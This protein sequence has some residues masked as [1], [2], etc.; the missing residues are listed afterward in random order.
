M[1]PLALIAAFAFAVAMGALKPTIGALRTRLA[2]FAIAGLIGGGY[3]LV[4]SRCVRKGS[5]ELQASGFVESVWEP[6]D[7][8]VAQ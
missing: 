4:L 3:L 7:P 2:A 5:A 1:V 8:G 6:A